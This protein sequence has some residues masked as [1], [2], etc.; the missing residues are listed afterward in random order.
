MPGEDSLSLLPE[1]RDKFN[2]IKIMIPNDLE[3]FF[4][5]IQQLV[6]RLIDQYDHVLHLSAQRKG[7]ATYMVVFVC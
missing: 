4:G 3:E 2:P 6:D 5:G 1:S 7:V